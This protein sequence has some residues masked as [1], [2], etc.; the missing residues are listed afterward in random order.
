MAPLPRGGQSSRR[1][2]TSTLS[3]GRCRIRRGCTWLPRSRP[4]V[5]RDARPSR[6]DRLGRC[7][8]ITAHHD[9]SGRIATRDRAARRERRSIPL[10][11]GQI[12]DRT[13]RPG[14]ASRAPHVMALPRPLCVESTR[15]FTIQSIGD[16]RLSL[17]GARDCA[18]AHTQRTCAR[19]PAPARAPC[20]PAGCVIDRT[21]REV[22][23]CN[24]EYP[25]LTFTAF[26]IWRRLKVRSQE[27]SP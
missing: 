8:R 6:K 17:K 10:R 25:V 11:N 23:V 5:E 7:R 24:E 3:G 21:R 22:G 9:G 18:D 1:A 20:A 16:V 15:H 4:A 14:S 12:A 13:G 26:A 27:S 19:S 2:L